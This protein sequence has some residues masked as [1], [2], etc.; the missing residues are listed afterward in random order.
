MTW[1]GKILTFVVMLAAVVWIYF[2][3]VS[4]VTRTNWKTE[5]EKYKAAYNTALATRTAEYN[6]YQSSEDA[7]RRLLINEQT[8]TASLQKQIDTLAVANKKVV[9]DFDVQQKVI[10][11]GDVEAVKLHANL[12]STLKELDAVRGRNTTLEDGMTKLVIAAEDAKREMIRA[13]NQA[14][15]AQSIAD[16]NAKKVEDLQTLVTEY[17][18]YG[19]NP[20]RRF[21]KNPPAV[22]SNLRGEVEQVNG[23]LVILSIGVDAGLSIGSVLDL[24]R[25]DGGGQYLGTVK[26]IDLREKTATATFSPRRANVPFNQLRPE[27]LPKKGDRVRPQEA[28]L[29]GK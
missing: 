23:D 7:L 17:K 21:E 26:V 9:A 28:T 8:R 6:R 5:Y 1:L 20:A 2:T 15:L 18:Q 27:E 14:K 4:Y 11:N 29:G 13:Q 24:S 25:L 10:S 19:L 16:D 12:D 3:A 22:L